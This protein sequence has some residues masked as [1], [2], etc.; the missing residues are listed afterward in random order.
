[1]RQHFLFMGFFVA[2]LSA[3]PRSFDSGYP[4]CETDPD[5]HTRMLGEAFVGYRCRQSRCVLRSCGDGKVDSASEECDDGNEDDWDGCDHLC[6]LRALRSPPDAGPVDGAA[7]ADAGSDAGPDAGTFDGGFSGD[8]GYRAQASELCADA[9]VANGSL[10][11][12]IAPGNSYIPLPDIVL[13]PAAV[14]HALAHRLAAGTDGHGCIGM[15]Q[16][17]VE[18]SPQ[19][20]LV[21]FFQAGD[22]GLQLQTASLSV[23]EACPGWPAAVSGTW[24]LRAE[25]SSAW[26]AVDRAVPGMGG[27]FTC[28]GPQ[29]LTLGGAVRLFA[30][31]QPDLIMS[32]EEIEISGFFS[33]QG[34]GGNP[35]LACAAGCGDGRVEGNEGCDDGNQLES[36]GCSSN[37]QLECFARRGLEALPDLDFNGDFTLEAWVDS[38]GEA[39]MLNAHGLRVEVGETAI[40]G[41][42]DDLLRVAIGTPPEGWNHWA[43]VYRR[44]LNRRRL[45]LNGSPLQEDFPQQIFFPQVAPGPH[46][47][48][49]LGALRVSSGERYSGAFVP[50]YPFVSDQQTQLNYEFRGGAGAAIDRSEA[51]RHSGMGEVI[52]GCPTPPT[53]GNAELQRGE[54]CDDGNLRPGDGCNEFCRLEGCGDGRLGEG[55][56]CDDGNRFD[57][58]GC[59]NDCSEAS[60]G[61]G[62]RRSDL[63]VGQIGFEACDDGN[64]TDSDGCSNTC[65]V[66]RCGDGL[67]RTGLEPGDEGFELCDDGNQIDTDAC[68]T[69]CSLSVCGDGVLR[70]DLELDAEGYEECDDGN[71]E[72]GDGCN[73]S[74]QNEQCGNGRIDPGES[75]DDGNVVHADACRNDCV[76]ARCGDGIR[77]VD[78]AEGQEAYEAC[79]D[80]NVVNTD[81]CLDL[82]L[83]AR[84]GDSVVRTDIGPGH[85]GYENCDDGNSEDDDE[86]SNACLDLR[87]HQI[88]RVFGGRARG[89]LCGLNRRDGLRCKATD[90]RYGLLGNGNNVNVEDPV[91]VSNLNGV[92]DVAVGDSHVCAA[93]EGGTV[94]C[95]GA[96]YAGQIGDGS[97]ENRNVPVAVLDLSSATQI[98]AGSETTCARLED[99]TVKCWGGN[100]SGMLGVGQ[101]DQ[102]YVSRRAVAVPGLSRVRQV[103]TLSDTICAV[104]MTGFTWCWGNLPYGSIYPGAG[105]PREALTPEL[106]R[107]VAG[108][109]EASPGYDFICLRMADNTV[110]CWGGNGSGQSGSTPGAQPQYT[111]NGI[112]GTLGATAIATNRNNGCA[113]MGNNNVHC[114]GSGYSHQANPIPNLAD[115]ATISAFGENGYCVSKS[116]Y[117]VHCWSQGQVPV[118]VGGW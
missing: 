8:A 62:L 10:R 21:T 55:E 87:T 104:G 34:Q 42:G 113:I 20:S 116:D 91:L 118:E 27:G 109:A 17:R 70:R 11:I 103:Y 48:A 110:S 2:I 77:R 92:I 36:D 9:P 111:L 22:N 60:C 56:D 86:C 95:W 24:R 26:V 98:A 51:K 66:A 69:D 68:R 102:T 72:P 64:E 85:L 1:M 96:N 89:L 29:T 71:V 97:A 47:S 74:C 101:N 67:L 3:C 44:D 40:F 49:T 35:P 46:A 81:A 38:E 117:S 114:W 58:D 50:V 4:P 33:S 100:S 12:G 57:S 83:V 93:L 79:D 54:L 105:G 7:L 18:L 52:I 53:C 25:E 115:A 13:D 63:I 14:G 112:V 65:Q 5:C 45:F 75:C 16:L 84:C 76:A 61:D 6:H 41:W 39:V 90:N 73:V 31:G 30:L 59:R 43:M 80:G 19:C 23:S 37:C 99:E 15:L 88:A 106:L 82:C 78:I 107:N 94:R 108:V 32:L 28:F